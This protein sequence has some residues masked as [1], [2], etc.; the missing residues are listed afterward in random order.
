MKNTLLHVRIPS[1]FG[2]LSLAWQET[3][4]GPRVVRI[5]LPNERPPEPDRA[6]ASTSAPIADLAARIEAYLAG[7]PVVFDLGL[8]A[9]EQCGEFQRKV[10]LAEFGIPHGWVSTYTRIAAHVQS[11]KAARAVGTALGR[12][13]FPI[14]IPCHRA[15]RSDGGLG[16]YRGGLTMKRALL[17]MEGVAFQS[18]T[19]VRMDKVWY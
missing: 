13:P 9:L 14:V 3:P 8:L 11:P 18:E 7:E 5:F 12:N 19:L 6:G 17:E 10:L 1:R 16:G 15:V 4:N 2:V